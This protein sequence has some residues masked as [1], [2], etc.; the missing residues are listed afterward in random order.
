[1][2]KKII[3]LFLVF[4]F[5]IN[6]FSQNKKRKVFNAIYSEV[7]STN[8]RNK[9]CII[10]VDKTTNNTEISKQNF[11]DVALSF[12]NKRLGTQVYGLDSSW[13]DVLTKVDKKKQELTSYNIRNLKV[14]GFAV[15]LVRND[16]AVHLGSE[17]VAY[18]ASGPPPPPQKYWIDSRIN[19]SGVLLFKKK[20][21]VGFNRFS[22][23]LDGEGVIYFLEKKKRKGKKKWQVVGVL[24]GWVA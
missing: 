5:S 8:F 19:L 2:Y 14:P 22:G 18:D 15:L 11:N 1:M 4:L 20:A 24:R 17:A 21:I 12:T 9:P 6:S 16:S 23:V 13:I 10:A 3:L 7:I